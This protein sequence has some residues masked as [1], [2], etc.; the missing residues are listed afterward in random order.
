MKAPSES[1]DETMRVASRVVATAPRVRDDPVKM[2][3]IWL[4]WRTFCHLIAGEPE[5]MSTSGLG[6]GQGF[7]L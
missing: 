5:E 4:G 2:D 6:M 3:G 7:R 1:R